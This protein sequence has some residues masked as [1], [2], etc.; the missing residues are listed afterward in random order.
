MPRQ[1]VSSSSKKE[2]NNSVPLE[3]LRP[4]KSVGGSYSLNKDSSMTLENE[5]LTIQSIASSG[6]GET[7]HNTS[8]LKRGLKARHVSNLITGSV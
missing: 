7:T 4:R 6:V 2:D 5:D 8:E 3:V 1:S